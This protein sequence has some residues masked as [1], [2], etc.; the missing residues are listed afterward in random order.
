MSFSPDVCSA[1][2]WKQPNCNVLHFSQLSQH[3]FLPL[4]PVF[5]GT[6]CG[7]RSEQLIRPTAAGSGRGEKRTL[8]VGAAV[9]FAKANN[10]L[11]LFVNSDL[12]VSPLFRLAKSV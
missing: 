6:L 1:L 2:N 4:D 10:L 11:G 3:S 7:R 9:E 8:S 5:L 12:L